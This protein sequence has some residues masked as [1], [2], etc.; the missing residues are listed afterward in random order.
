VQGNILLI[1][2]KGRDQRNLYRILRSTRS[3]LEFSHDLDESRQHLRDK[4]YD[5]LLVDYDNM[6]ADG[7]QFLRDVAAQ[8]PDTRI[9]ILSQERSK[10]RLVE[11]FQAG[12]LTN[13]IAKNTAIE[14]E[15]IVVTVEKIARRDLFGL[16]K[17]LTWGIDA[18]CE[19][20]RCSRDKDRVL[21]KLERFGEYLGLN[22]RL[23]ALANGVADEFVMNAVYNAPT[24]AQGNH[25]YTKLPRTQRVDLEPHEHVE[26]RFA[27]DGR[28]LALSVTD[29]FGSLTPE[30]I[31]KY[32]AKCF[33]RGEDQIGSESGGAGMGFYYI[34]E[35]L[36]QFI[37]NIDPG[38]KTEMIGLL[39]VS[40]S[41]R[42]FV[43]RPKS[44]NIF[45]K[46]R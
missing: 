24:D 22:S 43:E 2:I 17:Y 27:C 7:V 37:V 12:F 11:L 30:T 39:D 20:I 35:S 42:N 8:Q 6:G 14:A 44:F 21:Q 40:G 23:I 1:H 9:L 25:R 32:L 38:K 19:I 4:S 29:N 45:V 26:L 31:Q 13:L 33:A 41:Y 34:F 46:D 15:E 16:E 5:L 10:E 18:D 3:E 28:H 36:S